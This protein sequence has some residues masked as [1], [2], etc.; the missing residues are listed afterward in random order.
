MVDF[1]RGAMEETIEI[2]MTDTSGSG[3][4]SSFSSAV[5]VGVAVGEPSALIL[6]AIQSPLELANQSSVASG[7][8]DPW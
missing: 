1:A 7:A 8:S 6:G 4:A 2:P 3:D 5:L